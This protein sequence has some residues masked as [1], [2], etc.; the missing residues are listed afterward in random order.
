MVFQSKIDKSYLYVLISAII[1][2]GIA[3]ILPLFLDKQIDIYGIVI[4]FSIFFLTVGFLL[5]I[6]FS[7]SYTFQENHLLVKTGPIKKRIQYIEI[8]SVRPTKDILT[9]FRILSSIDALAISYRSSIMGEIKLSPKDKEA[10][11]SELGK[12]VP[13][14]K[15]NK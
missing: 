1:I 8:T 11:L 6:S 4:M 9:G 12:R 15:E 2:I 13:A 3:C 14:L 10:F 7:I 5:W